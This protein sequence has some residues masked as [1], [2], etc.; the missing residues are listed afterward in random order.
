MAQNLT[1]EG[2]TIS[3]ED[4]IN[5]A[6][7]QIW[8]PLPGQCHQDFFDLLNSIIYDLKISLDL[9]RLFDQVLH[10]FLD[11]LVTWFLVVLG[12]YRAVMVGTWW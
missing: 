12:Q 1:Q 5:H 6:A 9:R 7:A 2:P 11:D 4:D 10:S 3:Q 8:K